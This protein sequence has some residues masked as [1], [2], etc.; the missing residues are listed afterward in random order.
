MAALGV[1]RDERA[2][3]P[4]GT[5]GVTGVMEDVG[6][7]PEVLP[8][9]SVDA[10]GSVVV[11]VLVEGAPLGLEEEQV[12]VPVFFHVMD[13]PGLQLFGRVGE[14]AVVAVVA[15]AQVLR[16]PGAVLRFVLLGVVD[17][18]HSVVGQQAAFVALLRPLVVRTNIR[19]VLPVVQKLIEFLWLASLELKLHIEIFNGR[20]GQRPAT[21]FVRVEVAA[22]LVIVLTAVGQ[23]LALF[24]FEFGQ[25]KVLDDLRLAHSLGALQLV[26]LSLA[27]VSG[28]GSALPRPAFIFFA[29]VIELQIGILDVQVRALSIDE[30]FLL[31]TLVLDARLLLGRRLGGLLRH[32][33]RSGLLLYGLGLGRRLW[34]LRRRLWRVVN[35]RFNCLFGYRN[36]RRGRGRF[37]LLFFLAIL[38]FRR[39][40]VRGVTTDVKISEH[41]VD[42]VACLRLLVLVESI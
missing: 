35:W 29:V 16:I 20:E 36:R 37:K 26:L 7:A 17:A 24:D 14:R 4:V 32:G 8:V 13:Q 23:V 12:E 3:L 2:A 11:V 31:L 6:L 30:N 9:V 41:R 42:L 40:F 21:V 28:H 19:L 5:L 25:L 18:L 34:L 10:L 39:R 22:V 33:R 27:L 38:L 1:L 15:L